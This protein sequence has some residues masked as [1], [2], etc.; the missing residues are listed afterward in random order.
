MVGRGRRAV[1][2]SARRASVGPAAWWAREREKGQ[3]GIDEDELVP[4]P[5]ARAAIRWLKRNPPPPTEKISVV[6]GDY[7]TG[8]FLF[9]GE[10][11]IRAILDWEMCH[12]G[13][14][15]EDV[16]WAADPLWAFKQPERPG[17]RIAREEAFRLWDCLFYTSP[18]LRDRTRSRT[19]SSA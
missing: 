16:A 4:Q 8:N 5:V 11:N 15:L 7:R 18:T 2:F 3:E 1:G 19:R 12:L 13:D 9:D 14:P 6:H 10:G 17:G